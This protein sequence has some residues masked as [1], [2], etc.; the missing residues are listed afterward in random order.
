MSVMMTVS[1]LLNVVVLVPVCTGLLLDRAAMRAV[2]GERT[3]ARGILLSIYLAILTVSI[4][5]LVL[6]DARATAALFAVQIVYK[7][8]TP[9]TVGTLK[10][11]VVL[12][13]LAIAA[14]HTASLSSHDFSVAG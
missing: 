12:S 7:V 11:P 8:T 2:F 9:L 14:V 3:Q 6:G 10:N 4:A 1:L 5:L 13:N